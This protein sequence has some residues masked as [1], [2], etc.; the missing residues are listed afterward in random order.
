MWM[1][2]TQYRKKGTLTVLIGNKVSLYSEEDSIF[3]PLSLSSHCFFLFFI[4]FA[5]FVSRP[6]TVSVRVFSRYF[7]FHPL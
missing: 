7:G 1:L 5:L 2:D 3:I 4:S 6:E